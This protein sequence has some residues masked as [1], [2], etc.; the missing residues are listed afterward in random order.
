M[1]SDSAQYHMRVRRLWCFQD[2]ERFPRYVIIDSKKAGAKARARRRP[3]RGVN[4]LN[5]TSAA[6]RYRAIC[7]SK[8]FG[9]YELQG[10]KMLIMTVI[11]ALPLMALGQTA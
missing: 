2:N 5:P 3:I 4:F 6:T 7:R 11:T 9:R 10:M 1:P 8:N